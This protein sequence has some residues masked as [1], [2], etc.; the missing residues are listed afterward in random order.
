MAACESV[1]PVSGTEKVDINTA[2]LSEHS[3]SSA[4]PDSGSTFLL[5]PSWVSC[6]FGPSSH[7][8]GGVLEGLN[9]RVF[10]QDI[11]LFLKGEERGQAPSWNDFS[12]PLCPGTNMWEGSQQVD[13]D[14]WG[15]R[16]GQAIGV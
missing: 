9:C 15:A 14:S 5:R 6:D 12:D 11:A 10:I 4:Q 2:G 3:E 13:T 1:V 16:G 8:R 7:H